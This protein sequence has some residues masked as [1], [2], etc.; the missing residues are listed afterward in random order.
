MST[1]DLPIP[2]DQQAT[3]TEDAEVT[4]LLTT[5]EGQ[6]QKRIET[7]VPGRTIAT[8]KK[9]RLSS[10]AERQQTSSDPSGDEPAEEE[11]NGNQT[12]ILGLLRAAPGQKKVTGQKR[13]IEEIE[14]PSEEEEQAAIL[15]K[16]MTAQR[17]GDNT[18]AE[19]FFDI[20]ADLKA[21]SKP[22]AKVAVT[23]SEALIPQKSLAMVGISSSEPQIKEGGLS[24]YGKGVNTFQDMGLPTFFDKN[25]KELKGPLPLTIFNKKWQDAAILFHA[26]KRTKSEESSETKDR[27]SGLKF[28]S[29]WEQSFSDWT[30][31]HRAFHLA[32][33]DIYRFP[34]FA[35]WLLEHKANCDRMQAKDGFMTALR[36]D[37]QLRTNAFAHRVVINGDPSVPD[38]SVL[39][40]DIA[41]SVYAEA[42][43][44]DELGFRDTNPYAPGGPRAHLDPLTGLPKQGKQPFVK[45]YHTQNTPYHNQ[46]SQYGHNFQHPQ[47][48]QPQQP[49]YGHPHYQQPPYYQNPPGNQ[50]GP[51]ARQHEQ[52]APRNGGYKG[53]NFIPNYQDQRR[54][55]GPA[56][57]Q[58]NGQM[59]LSSQS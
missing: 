47:H 20:L 55:T 56:T 11:S 33:R 35:G 19:M 2:S 3:Q 1:G 6:T 54:G 14:D 5:E 18:R 39:R 28:Q 26:D 37:I 51:N 48:F 34:T 15:K 41:E 52:K 12:E 44:F 25:M 40:I 29:E 30:I 9:S 45:N 8:S 31:N 46:Q 36:Y 17:K 50:G 10:I 43:N 23:Y 38:I 22:K 49:Q 59:V 27:Y 53:K 21:K 13:S 7:Q 58:N 24:F 32:L 42:R 16:A 4:S 57:S